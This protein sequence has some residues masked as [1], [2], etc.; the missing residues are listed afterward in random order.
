MISHDSRITADA[1]LGPIYEVLF[2]IR[3]PGERRVVTNAGDFRNV[4]DLRRV[5]CSEDCIGVDC[6]DCHHDAADL[7]RFMP[8]GFPE[9]VCLPEDFDRCFEIAK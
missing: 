3:Q 7:K 5:S 4:I 8:P 2:L 1:A 9:P 6:R